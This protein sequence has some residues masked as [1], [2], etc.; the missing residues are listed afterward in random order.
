MD[1]VWKW[2]RTGSLC[3]MGHNW[4][5]VR[6]W[7]RLCD[8]TVPP[9]FRAADHDGAVLAEARRRKERTYPE[10]SG[11]GGRARLVV[12]A[13]EVGGRWSEETAK[14]LVALATKAQ[15][16]PFILQNRVRAA[17]LRR[18]GAV[19]AC[20]AARAF[21]ASLLDQR[22]VAGW[23]VALSS[24]ARCGQ[25][26]CGC[27]F[28]GHLSHSHFGQKKK[29]FSRR[30]AGGSE[31]TTFREIPTRHRPLHVRGQND[32]ERQ[33][34]ERRWPGRSG[35]VP[36][37]LVPKQ[38]LRSA[39]WTAPGCAHG[40]FDQSWKHFGAVESIQ[41]VGVTQGVIRHTLQDEGKI[42]YARCAS[43]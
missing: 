31:A 1:V 19:L 17:Y 34:F 27:T 13:A 38:T 37:L 32:G 15:A 21:T 20:L 2:S 35:Q 28:D 30:S 33:D 9:R 16:S 43:W 8:A 11:E 7:C 25:F 26:C 12:L 4:R 5:L 42:L 24:G 3:G 23:G 40:D 22:P 29:D 41:P 39:C 6:R 10:L 14:F 18:W 36:Q